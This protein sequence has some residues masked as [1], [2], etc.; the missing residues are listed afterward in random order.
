MR[1]DQESHPIAVAPS[2]APFEPAARSRRAW[3]VVTIVFLAIALVAA[4]AMAAVWRSDLRDAERARGAAVRQVAVLTARVD[5]L[6]QQLGGEVPGLESRLEA[7]R[8]ALR[9]A[10]AELTALAGPALADGR[11]FV[12]VVA[13]GDDQDPPRLVVDIQ[14][15]FT[16]QAAVDAALEDGVHPA[17]AG[18]NGYYIR[19][20]NPRWRIVEV[21]PDVLV[22]LT[23]PPHGQ[24]DDPAIVDLPRFGTLFQ[25]SDEYIAYSPY[26]ITVR[27]GVVVRIDEQYLP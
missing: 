12:Q 2:G 16:D 17:E 15:W 3:L 8:V 5:R 19:N 10:R 25:A 24:I 6:E 11:H 20:E 22:A 27:D 13:V 4:I 26:W 23:T 7:A 1:T 9:E 21:D 18:I 14:Q